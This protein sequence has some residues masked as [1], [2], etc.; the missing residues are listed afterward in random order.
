[1]V[2]VHEIIY[3]QSDFLNFMSNIYP[4][5]QKNLAINLK[6]FVMR[7]TDSIPYMIINDHNF[8]SFAL[9]FSWKQGKFVPVI[10]AFFDNY[11][12]IQGVSMETLL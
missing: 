7:L 8:L 3:V 11:I 4:I 10:S 5:W 2:Q 9:G 6:V 12:V 1:M